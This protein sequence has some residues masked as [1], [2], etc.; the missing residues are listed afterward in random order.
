MACCIRP[1]AV[2]VARSASVSNIVVFSL[3][4]YHCSLFPDSVSDCSVS[5]ASFFLFEFCAVPDVFA[6]LHVRVSVVAY[7]IFVSLFVGRFFVLIVVPFPAAPFLEVSVPEVAFLRGIA[8]WVLV[9][10]PFP[11]GVVC[12]EY[13][14]DR[15]PIA[16]LR[17]VRLRAVDIRSVSLSGV[18]AMA[19]SIRQDS[20]LGRVGGLLGPFLLCFVVVSLDS[21]YSGP[22]ENYGGGISI[23]FLLYWCAFAGLLAGPD[24]VFFSLYL[25]SLFPLFP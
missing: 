5:C 21:V 18:F 9:L 7:A 12:I 6:P 13:S 1:S 14:P 20:S 8:T 24:W 4:V 3:C 16:P 11:F 25:A 22:A 23:F 17:S 2:R 19:G 10:F 15:Y